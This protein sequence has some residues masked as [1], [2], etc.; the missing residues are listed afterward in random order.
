MLTVSRET[1]TCIVELL[2]DFIDFRIIIVKS[3]LKESNT[4]IQDSIQNS[5]Q[6]SIQ[7]FIQDFIQLKDLVQSEDITLY[8]NSP[9]PR[10]R[11]NYFQNMIDITIYMFNFMSSFANFQTFRLKKLN[12][13]FEKKVFKIINIKD[14][15]IETRVFENRFINQMKNE[16]TEKAFE[17]SRLMI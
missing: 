9:R 11:L 16:E 4:P 2:S 10:Q 8:R 15:S 1:E 6:D 17:K 14:F 7:D 12:E 3:Y 13:L 5:I